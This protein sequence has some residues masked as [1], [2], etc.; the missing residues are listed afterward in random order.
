MVSL[1]LTSGAAFKILKD[2][3]YR[4]SESASGSGSTVFY[5]TPFSAEEKQI[6]VQE[7][8]TDINTDAGTFF[9]EATTASGVQYLNPF[10]IV[11][12]AQNGSG[13]DILFGKEQ[14][15]PLQ[16]T[17]TESVATISTAIDNGTAGGT[18]YVYYTEDSTGSKRNGKIEV[19]NDGNTQTNTV[20]V[21]ENAVV[22]KSDDGN[23]GGELNIN[24]DT[25]VLNSRSGL[26]SIST[27]ESAADI[28]LSQIKAGENANGK[29]VVLIQS[30]PIDK[31]AFFT[32]NKA[33]GVLK[34][35]TAVSAAAFAANTSLIANDTATFGGYTIGQVVAA[36]KAYGLLA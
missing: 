4:F 23:G 19:S 17:V 6:E 30:S 10:Y 12:V 5:F 27:E 36:L 18:T 20:Y 7:T 25:A 26:G 24:A 15:K 9:V 35:T 13:A 33:S 8:T 21:Q 14:N 34:Q 31:L 29:G 3:I 16:L 1:T 32:D 28:V 2:N 22:V 11:T